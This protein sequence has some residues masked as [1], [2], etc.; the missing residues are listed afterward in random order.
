MIRL[1]RSRVIEMDNLPKRMDARIGPSGSLDRND[2]PVRHFFQRL[3]D[4]RLDTVAVRLDL[5]AHITCSVILHDAF[6]PLCSHGWRMPLSYFADVCGSFSILKGTGIATRSP[7]SFSSGL[8]SPYALMSGRTI[9]TLSMRQ[10]PAYSTYR[11]SANQGCGT[12]SGLLRLDSHVP[13]WH[14]PIHQPG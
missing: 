2:L 6:V 1:N 12:S 4:F 11:A 8:I 10:T 5:V 7:D 9:T 13:P 14:L 3:F